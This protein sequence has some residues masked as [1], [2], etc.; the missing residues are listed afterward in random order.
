MLR[1]FQTY[2][3][4]R[5]ILAENLSLVLLSR[6]NKLFYA[7]FYKMIIAKTTPQEECLILL[8]HDSRLFASLQPCCQLCRT[9]SAKWPFPFR[10]SASF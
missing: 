7:A 10:F 2:D 1:F 4:R 9:I 3:F 8:E 6:E 5:F